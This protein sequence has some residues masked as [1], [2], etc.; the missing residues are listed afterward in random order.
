MNK[1]TYAS[2]IAFLAL[3]ALP[4]YAS[5]ISFS[6]TTVNVTKGQTFTLAVVANAAGTKSYTVKAEV[7]Y[8][9][10]LLEAT[11]F[12][13]GSGWMPLSAGGYDTIDNTAGKLVKTGGFTGGFTDAKTL[14]TITFK[15]K[16]NGTATVSVSSATIIYDAQNKNT[17]SGTQ[18]TASVTIASAAPAVAPVVSAP[19]SSQPAAAGAATPKRAE[20]QKTSDAVKEKTQDTATTAA[21]TA[22]VATTSE[23]EVAGLAQAAAAALSGISWWMWLLAALV[24]LGG[25]W[26]WVSRR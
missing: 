16:A 20:S 19:A 17:L 1:I 13:F 10:A 4:A 26:Y 22:T 11:G 9:T 24:I 23:E 15:A 21:A 14:G 2:F 12:V 6:P 7:A 18:G 5:T 8:P 3:A 25:A